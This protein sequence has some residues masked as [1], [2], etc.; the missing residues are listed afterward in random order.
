MEKKK[1]GVAVGLGG[2]IMPLAYEHSIQL[3]DMPMIY[4]TRKWGWTC[5]VDS[6]AF[7]LLNNAWTE[8]HRLFID[9]HSIERLCRIVL[10]TLFLFVFIWHDCKLLDFYYL[11]QNQGSKR[12]LNLFS[13]IKSVASVS[14]TANVL[15]MSFKLVVIGI[16]V[17]WWRALQHFIYSCFI[18][19]RKLCSLS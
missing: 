2:S 19:K 13:V 18:C 4:C 7:L 14:R 17:D 8:D 15:S 11:I 9:V 1:Q 10:L 16:Y 12:L 6:H 3:N 5:R